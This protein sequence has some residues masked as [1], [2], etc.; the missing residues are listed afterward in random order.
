[1]A[2]RLAAARHDIP[3]TLFLRLI[4]QESNWNPKAL[5][6]K[7]AFGLTQLMPATA[8]M[9]GVDRSDPEQN[10]DGG[11]RYLSQQ[12]QTFGNWRL[13]LAAYNAGPAA[14]TKYRG[15]PPYAETRNYVATILKGWE[16]DA[17]ASRPP[18]PARTA[19][20]SVMEF[21]ASGET[22]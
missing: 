5:S 4:K 3:E 21:T 9:M 1:M 10:L 22:Q 12:Y 11:A 16:G 8:R 6:P 2:A 14:V 13:A 17:V 20:T 18:A 7:G 19:S 15:I